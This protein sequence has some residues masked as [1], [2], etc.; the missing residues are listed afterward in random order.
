MF[1]ALTAIVV[2]QIL[3]EE[4]TK[5]ILKSSSVNIFNC[6]N[7]G[8]TTKSNWSLNITDGIVLVSLTE[9]VMEIILTELVT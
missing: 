8:Y 3:T 7:S 2:Q 6:E 1:L 5:I 4:K 9:V